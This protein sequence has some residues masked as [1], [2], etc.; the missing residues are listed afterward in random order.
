MR[1]RLKAVGL[2]A[3]VGSGVDVKLALRGGSMRGSRPGF[4]R[5][6]HGADDLDP[7]IALRIGGDQMPG[8][9][10]LVGAGEHVLDRLLVLAT[11]GPVGQSSSVSFQALSGSAA[12]RSKRFSCSSSEMWSQSLTMIVPSSARLRSKR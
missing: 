4:D 11:L 3:R 1:N 9:A 10:R 7:G 8:S 6:D 2:L 5:L 12:R